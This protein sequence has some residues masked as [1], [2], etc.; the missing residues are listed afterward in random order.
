MKGLALRR[1]RGQCGAVIKCRA[2]GSGGASGEI[3]VM[4]Q[5]AYTSRKGVQG[6]WNML[7]ATEMCIVM[8]PACLDVGCTWFVGIL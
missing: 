1:L 8:F 5:R 6:K 7:V 3:F 2:Q 4:V